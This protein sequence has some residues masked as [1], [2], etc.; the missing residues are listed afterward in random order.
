MVLLN[1]LNFFLPSSLLIARTDGKETVWQYSKGY[2]ERKG[3]EEITGGITTPVT[4]TKFKLLE[5]DK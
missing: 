4:E 3:N 2:E 1:T 5:R